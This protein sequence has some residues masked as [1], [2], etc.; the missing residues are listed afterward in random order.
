MNKDISSDPEGEPGSSND[1]V[2]RYNMQ[3]QSTVGM[4]A[5]LKPETQTQH[6]ILYNPSLYSHHQR[7]LGGAIEGDRLERLLFP[8]WTCS[9]L[10]VISAM[11]GVST[12]SGFCATSGWSTSMDSSCS[13]PLDMPWISA[14]FTLSLHAF[15]LA[16][17]FLW[18]SSRRGETPAPFLPG[19]P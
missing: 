9:N 6:V 17:Y 13:T 16:S 5:E 1:T 14:I 15:F 8:R 7:L 19:A 11:S 12:A 2:V 3:V 10:P 18:L 4:G